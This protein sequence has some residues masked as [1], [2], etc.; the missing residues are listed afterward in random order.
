MITPEGKNELDFK[1]TFIDLYN[2][3]KD[4]FNFLYKSQN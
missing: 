1:Q 2:M 4:Q 3:C